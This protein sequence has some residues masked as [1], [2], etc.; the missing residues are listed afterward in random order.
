MFSDLIYRLRALF[1]RNRMESDLDEEIRLHVE[2]ETEAAIERGVPPDEARRRAR[3]ALGG[4]EQI[5]EACRDAR[6]VV[7]LET[8]AQDVRYAVRVLR[9]SRGYSVAAILTL[10]LGIG[11][12]T[13]IFTLVNGFLLRP[14][15]VHE[16]DRLVAIR[17][18]DP[19]RPNPYLA[20]GVWEHIGDR[21]ELFQSVCGWMP[22]LF[23]LAERG[24]AD[25]VEGIWVSG[26]FFET[27]GVPAILGRTF[28]AADDRQGG[29]PNGPVAVISHGYWQRRFVGAADAVGRSLTVNRVSYTIVGVTP[30]RF[31]GPMA[32]RSFDVALTG[33]GDGGIGWAGYVLGRLAPGQTPESATAALRAL[34]PQ[35]REATLAAAVAAG[36]QASRWLTQPLSATSAATG[37]AT[38]LSDRFQRPLL[39]MLLLAGLVVL[40][41]CGNVANLVLARATARRHEL[42]VRRALGASR[43]RL[44]RQV[45]VE[46]LLLSGVGAALGLV[47]AQVFCPFLVRQISTATNP[48]ALDLSL[49]WR[50]LAFTGG[51]S[52]FTALLFGVVPALRAASVQPHDALKEGGRA[53]VGDQRWGVNQALIVGQVG[54]SVVLVVAAGLFVR[55]FATMATM[56]LGFDR[57]RTVIVSLN[58]QDARVPPPARVVLYERLRQAVAAVPGVADAVSLRTAPVSSDHWVLDVRVAGQE[59]PAAV[60]TRG[61]FLN[62]VSRGYFATFGA[63]ILAGR[64]FGDRDIQGAPLVAVVNE[65]FAR[66]YLGGRSPV[67]ETLTFGPRTMSSPPF[68]IVG[69]ARDAG[70]ATYFGLREGIPPTVYLSI[71]Q[72]NPAIVNFTPPADLRIGVRLTGSTSASVTRGIAAAVGKVEPDLRVRMRTM[73]DYIDGTLIAERLAAILAGLFGSLALFLAGVGIFGVTAYAVSRRR[74]EF[75]VRVALGASTGDIVRTVLQ[76]VVILVGLGLVI[77]GAA[78][79]WASRLVAALLFGLEPRDPATFAATAVVL[80]AVALL[81]GWLPARRAARIDP[82]SVMRSL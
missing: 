49:D 46:S 27:L 25:M 65:T 10:A 14:L 3:L 26:R 55:T 33:S 48:A 43:T 75:G 80:A 19:Q 82:A 50:V 70:S 51:I 24:E 57:T 77:G 12:T 61:P 6:G 28:T 22:V 16:P 44:A 13:A 59:P 76:R 56:D 34:Q 63:P 8:L 2:R 53:R 36:A 81:A 7:L 64:G 66:L 17:E 15:P 35:I 1:R 21:P 40:V 73:A 69:L 47:F 45:L 42:S 39:A 79:F 58:L 67:G 32:G 9:K 71:A 72:M 29:G 74:A 11:A 37:T 4:Q 78:S 41:A 54:L 20:T 68:Q 5:K 38:P 60:A 52:V 30:P 18:N 62:A 23:N 31:L